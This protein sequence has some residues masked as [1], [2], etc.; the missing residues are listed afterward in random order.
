MMV[1]MYVCIYV[2]LC[3]HIYICPIDMGHIDECEI[4]QL[5]DDVPSVIVKTIGDNM[6]SPDAIHKSSADM[7]VS[8]TSN[9]PR[10]SGA[11]IS[12]CIIVWCVVC[13]T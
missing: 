8:V 2:M 10:S 12:M 6:L 4:E 3:S 9:L 7:D 1:C 11:G 5:A 13:V